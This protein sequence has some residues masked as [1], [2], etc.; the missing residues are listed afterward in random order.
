MRGTAVPSSAPCT[1]APSRRLL[2]VRTDCQPLPASIF[3]AFDK[4]VS[5]SLVNQATPYR[6]YSSLLNTVPSADSSSQNKKRWSLFRSMIPFNTIPGNSRPGEVTPPAIADEPSSTL[7]SELP[8]LDAI[9][10]NSKA[11]AKA[12]SPESRPA[13]PRYQPLTFKFSL[14]WLERPSWPAKNRHLVAPQLPPR[15]QTLLLTHRK[16]QRLSEVKPKKPRPEELTKSKYSGRALAEWALVVQE[17][18]SFFDRRREE[19]VPHDRLVETPMLGVE[20]F[21]ISG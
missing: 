15:A 1:P 16:G 4:L 8:K 5:P 14:E 18:G 2:I 17:C 3:N 6:T 13:S 11:K 12:E 20:S 9:A 7:S 21:R 19:G 10:D